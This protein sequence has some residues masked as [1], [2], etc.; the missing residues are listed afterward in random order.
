[1]TV[2]EAIAELKRLAPP[3]CPTS[4]QV[5]FRESP[6]STEQRKVEV[7]AYIGSNPPVSAL[8]Y[9]VEG[10]MA[11]ISRK[12]NPHLPADPDL[13]AAQVCAAVSDFG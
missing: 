2:Q 13:I 3:N 6:L 10:A 11:E 12:L 4:L 8:E 9:S 5:S 7:F 1:M